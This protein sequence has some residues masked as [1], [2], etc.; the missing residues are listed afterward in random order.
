[1]GVSEGETS[2][3]GSSVTIQG[4]GYTVVGRERLRA[5]STSGVAEGDYL[6]V[7][8]LVGERR[9]YRAVVDGTP[10]PIR[11]YGTPDAVIAKQRESRGEPGGARAT[12]SVTPSDPRSDIE[13]IELSH[14]AVEILEQYVKLKRGG[15]QG[16]ILSDLVVQHLGPEVER[17]KKA[18]EAIQQLPVDL[19]T[20]LASAS[21]EQREQILAMLAK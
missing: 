13:N 5:S 6:V 3:S 12:A 21:S 19:L 7:Y 9:A 14:E 4:R 10:Y 8:E 18:Q 1:M 2:P 20:R 15:D 17:L 11:Q 16:T